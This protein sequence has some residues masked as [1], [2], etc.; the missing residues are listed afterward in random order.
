[1]LSLLRLLLDTA[2]LNFHFVGPNVRMI[3]KNQTFS[4]NIV[5]TRYPP[6]DVILSLNV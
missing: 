6:S 4:L 5:M 3:F 2:H 1:M